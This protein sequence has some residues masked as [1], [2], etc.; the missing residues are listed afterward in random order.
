[1]S[2]KVKTN[3]VEKYFGT[4]YAF[5][6]VGGKSFQRLVHPARVDGMTYPEKNNFIPYNL[7]LIDE[8]PVTVR[9]D[10]KAKVWFK[11]DDRFKQ[12]KVFLRLLIETPLGCMT[13]WIIWRNPNYM[14][15]LCKRA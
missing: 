1:M 2:Q 6:E 12:P 4:E 10:E 14:R 11:F 5:E 15:W 9:D 3:K 13:R 8:K 7:A